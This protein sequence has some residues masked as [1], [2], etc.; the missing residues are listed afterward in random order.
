MDVV[1]FMNIEET[2]KDLIISFAL[3]IGEGYIKTLL[4][5]RTLFYE[6][7]LPDE[8]RGTNV[9]LEGSDLSKEHINSLECITFDGSVIKI[10]ARF[11]YHEIDLVKIDKEELKNIEKSLILHNY[12]E[13]FEV[14]FI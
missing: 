7:I 6:F 9:S 4:L 1:S 10:K 8:E 2:E 5:H 12:D 14:K 11:S 13:R 3:D